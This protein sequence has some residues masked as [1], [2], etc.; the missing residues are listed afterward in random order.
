[1]LVKKLGLLLILVLFLVTLAVP[2]RSVRACSGD[3]CDCGTIAQECRDA[4]GPVWPCV[5]ACNQENLRCAR[6]C[7][8]WPE[9]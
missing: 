7:C 9:I 6:A 2:T 4:C 8:G 1:M 5:R 3:I